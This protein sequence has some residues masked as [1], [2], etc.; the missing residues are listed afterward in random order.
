MDPNGS[1]PNRVR[2]T[3]SESNVALSALPPNLPDAQITPLSMANTHNSNPNH[4]EI[5][6][7]Q[8]EM[9][10]HQAFLSNPI[11][12]YFGS[13]DLRRILSMESPSVTSLLQGDPVAVVHAHLNTIGA[14]D[15]GPIFGIPTTHVIEEQQNIPHRVLTHDATDGVPTPLA[16]FMASPHG[17]R[18]DKTHIGGPNVVT[19]SVIVHDSTSLRKYKCKICDRKF[20]S[21]QAYGG[22]M[23]FHSIERKKRLQS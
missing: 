15:D 17:L 9:L 12:N 5:I 14:T 2:S 6:E 7:N 22:H 20:N 23:K 4:R 1:Y 16:P 19:E 11:R 21:Y 8:P 10:L 18:E 3:E 13:S